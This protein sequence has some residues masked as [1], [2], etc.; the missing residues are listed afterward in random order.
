MPN[1]S[2]DRDVPD[3]RRED[4]ARRRGLDYALGRESTTSRARTRPAYDPY[5]RSGA[6]TGTPERTPA[7]P[8]QPAGLRVSAPESFDVPCQTE[9]RG[10]TGD[11]GVC[12][13]PAREYRVYMHNVWQKWIICAAHAAYYRSWGADLSVLID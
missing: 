7:R 12:G 2:R 6:T 11:T 1:Y 10:M 9:V 8:G 5:G 4:R 13:A 3:D